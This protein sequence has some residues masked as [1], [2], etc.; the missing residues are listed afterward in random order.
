MGENILAGVIAGIISGIF[1]ILFERLLVPK[2]ENTEEKNKEVRIIEP[3]QTIIKEK[4]VKIVYISN[5]YN[6]NGNGLFFAFEE[7]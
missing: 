3:R 6:G 5:W 4:I 2:S 1:L 7:E